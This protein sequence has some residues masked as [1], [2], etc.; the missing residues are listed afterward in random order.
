[1]LDGALAGA[2]L[3]DSDVAKAMLV[4]KAMTATGV[5]PEVMAQVGAKICKS[6]HYGWPVIIRSKN[7]L[8]RSPRRNTIICFA[9][10]ESARPATAIALSN[11]ALF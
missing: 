6:C 4:Q 5:T 8:C 10:S 7:V 1:M 2:G 3:A 9:T 11:T